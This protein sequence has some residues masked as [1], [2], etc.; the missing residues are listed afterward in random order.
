MIRISY[1]TCPKYNSI[2]PLM[3][4]IFGI[5]RCY[6]CAIEMT[7]FFFK[8][9]II[10]FYFSLTVELINKGCPFIWYNMLC[11]GSTLRRSLNSFFLIMSASFRP[12]HRSSARTCQ[13]PALSVASLQPLDRIQ[14][15]YSPECPEDCLLQLSLSPFHLLSRP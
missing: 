12:T 6:M 2:L 1:Y 7:Y 4:D 13:S 8:E 11:L 3:Y 15:S 5:V 10:V 14:T 9:R